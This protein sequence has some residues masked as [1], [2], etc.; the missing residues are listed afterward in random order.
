MLESDA[1]ELAA[2]R[3]AGGAVETELKASVGKT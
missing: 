2:G 3:Q 1:A